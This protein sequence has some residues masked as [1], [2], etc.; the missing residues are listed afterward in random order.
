MR[1]VIKGDKKA[2][3]AAA[4]TGGMA[5]RE[6]GPPAGMQRR[7]ERGRWGVGMTQRDDKGGR[8]CRGGEDVPAEKD[9]GLRGAGGVVG[10]RGVGARAVQVAGGSAIRVS[11]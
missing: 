3:E 4:N 10:A 8:S 7:R 5:S 1:A 11:R 2:G 6:V 9:G